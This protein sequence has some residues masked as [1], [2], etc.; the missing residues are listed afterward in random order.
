MTHQTK[1]I[2]TALTKKLLR[3]LQTNP[4]HFRTFEL[5]LDGLIDTVVLTSELL[6]TCWMFDF[7]SFSEYIRSSYLVL[8]GYR[9]PSYTYFNELSRTIQTEISE[10]FLFE[11]ESTG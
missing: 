11:D 3:T 1:I 7:S 4:H 8:T 6:K 9:L 10:F 5:T 2:P